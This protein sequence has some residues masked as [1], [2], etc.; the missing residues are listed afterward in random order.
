[1]WDSS[2]RVPRPGV[3]IAVLNVGH[4]NPGVIEAIRRQ[5]ET[6]MQVSNLFYSE[7][8]AG[9]AELLVNNSFADKCFSATAGRRPTKRDQLLA[10]TP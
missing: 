6:L 1:V 9:L 5:S 3:G 8:Q 2:G 10:S 7:P 4:L